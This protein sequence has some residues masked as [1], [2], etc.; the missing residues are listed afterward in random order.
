MR[1]QTTAI[2][3]SVMMVL[4]LVGLM[5][6]PAAAQDAE[7]PAE[8]ALTADEIA[9][10]AEEAAYYKG[11]D[12]RSKVKMVIEEGNS[13]REREFV[14]LRRNVTEPEGS[15]D[16][17]FYVYFLAPADVRKTVYRVWKHPGKEDDRWLYLPGLDLVN[18]IAA[19]DKRTSFMG[20]HFLYED[21]SGRGLD[22][23]THELL[24]DKETNTYWVLKNVPKDPRSVEFGSYEVWVHKR[25]FLPVKS[26]Y[27][28][29][30]GKAY[31][32]IQARKVELVDEIPTVTLSEAKDLRTGGKTTSTFSEVK[33]N[34]G[35]DSGIFTEERY[36]RQAPREVR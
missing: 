26:T 10:K 20:S 36:L 11:S 21:V 34:I 13:K 5:L 3:F 12:G 16:Q 1:I 15:R 24:A 31:R 33:Y 6:I 27:Y 17:M 9:A 2:S 4:L 32:E 8:K 18:R 35:L 22:Q 29:K 14:I 7:Q 23:D 19:S 25:T 28:D 30:D